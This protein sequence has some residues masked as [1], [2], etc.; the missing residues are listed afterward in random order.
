MDLDITHP[1]VS[2]LRRTARKRLP[3]FAFEYLD[4]ATG[5]EIGLR[6]NR[7]RL[8]A[9]R[10]M[11]AIL[12]GEVQ[13]RLECSFLG[14]SYRL[15]VGIAPVGMSGLIWPGAERLLAEAA[16]RNHVPYC[17]STVAAALPEEIG[18]VAAEMG[19]FQLYPP[20][21]GD[22]R[23][24]ML[25]R[26]KAA[27]FRKLVLTVDVPGESRR[28]R[29]RR[30]HLQMP[31]KPTARIIWSLLTHPRWTLAMLREGMPKMKL[32]ESYVTPAQRSSDAFMHAGRVIRGWPDWDGLR[33]IRDEWAGDLIVK[34]VLDPRDA[35]RL[36][37]AGVDAI[38][39]SN[40]SARQFEAGPAAID[41]LPL[42]RDAV[43]PD[44]PLAFDSGVSGGLD[45]LRALALG[46]D[47]VFLGRAFH[48]ALGAFGARGVQHLLHLLEADM[49]ANMSQIGAQ[50][51][52][53]L[54]PR[55][56][57]HGSRGQADTP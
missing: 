26:A 38:W 9:L 54:L 49:R 36:A 24:D 30:A 56:I 48:Y 10:F 6:H 14:D 12:G 3:D 51:F 17:L 50:S 28:E 25:A 41:Q 1:A 20:A 37:A 18:P 32:A 44:M 47:I 35:T 31:P 46:A 4:S 33:A 2:D 7:D 29:Q 5:S 22:I 23:R 57:G 27:G 43:G 21:S 11:P 55:L 13:A 19:W 42:I 40:H 45:I 39:V 16:R 34:G 53:A 8:D 52:D 15:P